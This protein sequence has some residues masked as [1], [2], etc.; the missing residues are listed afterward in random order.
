MVKS[1]TAFTLFLTLMVMVLGVTAEANANA[2]ANADAEKPSLTFKRRSRPDQVRALEA[3]ATKDPWANF[4]QFNWNNWSGWGWTGHTLQYVKDWYYDEYGLNL[5][6]GVYSWQQLSWYVTYFG[7]YA[8]RPTPSIAVYGVANTEAPWEYGT[9]A[10][11]TTSSRAASSSAAASSSRAASSSSSS[12]SAALSSSS[13]RAASSSSSSSATAAPSSSSSIAPSSS[14]SSRAASSSSSSSVAP[15]SSSSSSSAAASSS[16]SSRAASS[17]SSSSSSAAPSSSSSSSS[18]AASSSSSSSSAAASSSS[19][20]VAA[21]SSSSSSSSSAAASSSSS[22]ASSS[23]AA[24]SSSSSSSA[25]PSAT[26]PVIPSGWAAASS[27]CIADG[28]SGRGLIGTFTI[29]Y[30]NT[31][32]SCLARCDNGGY[33]L[34]GLEYGNQCFCG[35]YLSNGASL[36][37]TAT[38]NVNCP[39]DS[40]GSTKCGGYYAMSL[41]VSTKINA[42]ALTP[43]LSAAVETLPSGWS[44]AAKCMPEVSGRALTDLSYF[45]DGMTT[46]TCL[47][48]C[49]ARGYQY[50]GVEYGRE[51]YCGNSIDNGADLTKTSTACGTPCAGNP[52]VPCGGQNALT[53]YNNPAYSYSN[54]VINGYVKTA[55]LQEVAN[56]ALRGASYQDAT[57]MTVDTCTQ[58]CADRGYGMA[59]VEYG[60]ECYCGSALTGGASLLLTSGQCY[61]PCVGDNTQN[62]GGP[63]AMWLY[64]NPTPPA[65]AINL[66]TGWTYQGCIAEGSVGRA[67]NFTATNYLAKG[68]NTG[69]VCARQ[70]AIL[71][72]SIA[73]TEYS[74]QCYCGNSFTNGASGNIIDTLTDGTGQCNYPCP[75]NTAQM[76]G[77]ANRLSIY[78]SLATLPSTVSVP[79]VSR[80]AKSS[81]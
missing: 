5:P 38:C 81:T 75:A 76:C 62:C 42:A 64:I 25:A 71:G 14:S 44:Q 4:Y 11:S 19:S 54:T 20:S 45:S 8:P 12:S 41:Y 2:N 79:G 46:A 24:S 28:R 3:R 47:N 77:G 13:S 63:N 10:S 33:P 68:S 56:R 73:G 1:A 32:A 67:L 59:A 21:S 78:S 53:V 72:Y 36:T 7:T 27:P 34:G 15:S 55:C 70:C 37:N 35:S 65:A 43:D 49:A 74:E 40:T 39:G 57:G 31:I 60:R 16:S 52:T 17:S 30:Q 22:S 58:Y 48:Y 23:I 50:A 80:V 51:C 29:D 9:L 61:M 6:D 66:P 26:V 18:A 69:E